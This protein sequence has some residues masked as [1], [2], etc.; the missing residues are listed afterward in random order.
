MRIAAATVAWHRR[1]EARVILAVTVLVALSI[2]AILIT[3]T[4]VVAQR[5]SDRALADLGAARAAFLRLA[6][7][8]AAFAAAQSSLV[9]TLPVFRAHLTDDRLVQDLAT[10]EALADHYRQ[11]LKADFAIVANRAGA[12]LATS[13]WPSG[14]TPP[15]E[16]STAIAGATGGRPA[17]GFV[18][19][20]SRLF[21]LV[22]QP[23]LFADEVLGSLTVGYALDDAFA[24]DV[25]RITGSEITLAADGHVYASSLTA[26]DRAAF[27]AALAAGRWPEDG[28]FDAVERIGDGEYVL[29][30]FPLSANEPQSSPARLVMLEDWRP[31]HASLTEIRF[32]FLSAGAVVFIL[33]LGM[34]VF[35]SRRV[36]RPLETL[37][38]AAKDIA[39]GNWSRQLPLAGTAEEVAM[40]QAVNTMTTGLRHWYEEA[41]S[42]DDQLRQ[43]QKLE[44]LGRLAGGIAHD[45]NNFL[46]AIKGY[47]GLLLEGLEAGDKRRSKVEGIL[48]AADTAA[49]LTRQLLAFSRQRVVEVRVLSLERVLRSTEKMLKRLIAE[50]IE[51][52][53]TICREIGCVRADPN[54]IEQILVNLVVNARDAMPLGGRIAIELTEVECLQ[55]GATGAAALS[56][57]RYVRLSVRDTGSGITPEVKAR[58]FEPFFTTKPEG[59]GTGLGLAVVYGIVEQL[60][61]GI[62]VDTEIGRGTTFHV[63]LPHTTE[64]EPEV[65]PALRPAAAGGTETILLVEDEPQ[66][67]DLISGA[68]EASGYTV[69]TAASGIQALE[70]VRSRMSPIHLLLT[71]VVMPGM[72][73]RE[74]ADRIRAVRDGIPTLYISG[75]SDDAVLKHGVQTAVAQFLPKPFSMDALRRKI[76]DVLA[77]PQP[78]GSSA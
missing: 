63:H 59:A 71:D 58:I 32:R 45:F 4:R 67:A 47:S 66:V 29:G 1:F 72:N 75:Y 22:A 37:A 16:L 78:V 9:T 10:L 26:V 76:R 5:S 73:G 30:A 23:A 49:G 44:A 34:S 7:E 70:I 11:D 39:G 33:A 42:R 6:D 35:F 46:T 8:R 21:L 41:K 50:D 19:A 12:W 53:T 3:T 64:R 17:R 57:G 55:G 52:T 51:L 65:N 40:A 61:G 54:Q 68:L 74:L 62:A 15:R 56:P 24:A 36:A 2:T 31:T 77:A 38:D 43:A 18:V 20:G 13:E 60:G 27:A 28:M 14:V 25:A 69:L 48:K